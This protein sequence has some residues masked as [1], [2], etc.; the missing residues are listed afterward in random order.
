MCGAVLAR[1]KL[2]IS[3]RYHP[4]IFASL[5]G[6]PCVFLGAAAHKMSSLQRV[7]EYE[8][9]RD[10]SAFPNDDEIKAICARSGELLKR[11]E[12]LREKVKSVAKRRCEEARQITNFIKDNI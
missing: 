11:G 6:T 12:Q 4:A 9:I 8:E 10:F 2:F 5:G 3:G 7:L 1:A